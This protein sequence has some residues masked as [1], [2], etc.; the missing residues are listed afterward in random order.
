MVLEPTST[1]DRA[2]H[3]S[4]ALTGARAATLRGGVVRGTILRGWEQRDYGRWR[5]ESYS[6]P[7]V[8]SSTVLPESAKPGLSVLVGAYSSTFRAY[9]MG[10]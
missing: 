8:S 10:S 1:V 4:G 2:P 5:H 3:G 7:S 9:V 6:L